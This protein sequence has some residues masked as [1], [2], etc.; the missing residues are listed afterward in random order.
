MI[1]KVDFSSSKQVRKSLLLASF[2][3]ISFDMIVQYSTGNVEFLGFKIPVD[4]ADIIPKLIGYLI[5]YFVVALIIRYIVELE[6]NDFKTFI[7]NVKDGASIRD[8]DKQ[9]VSNRFRKHTSRNRIYKYPIIFID[10]IFPVLF[11]LF[12]L[13]RIFIVN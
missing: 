7:E 6:K 1:D 12:V 11:G 8:D 5:V 4:D 9:V 13:Y 2:A 3:G 10:L